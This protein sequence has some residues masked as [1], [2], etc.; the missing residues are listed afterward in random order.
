MSVCIRGGV[1]QGG[2][3]HM[4]VKKNIGNP[5]WLWGRDEAG[6]G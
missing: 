6:F 1:G 4:G 5:V 3:E 2:A